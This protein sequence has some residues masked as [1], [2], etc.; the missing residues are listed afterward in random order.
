M[1]AAGKIAAAMGIVA[2]ALTAVSMPA[3]A[4]LCLRADGH[5]AIE[6]PRADCCAPCDNHAPSTE[7][8]QT[9]E[10]ST[11]CCIDI[12]LPACNTDPCTNGLEKTARDIAP[13]QTPMQ[14]ALT[15]PVASLLVHAPSYPPRANEPPT[16][17]VVL[18]I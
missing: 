9:P 17:T 6:P 3:G 4:V 12:P 14:Q 16:A 18:L 5:I 13:S 10:P 15:P 1:N 8:S 11:R 7:P 2:Y